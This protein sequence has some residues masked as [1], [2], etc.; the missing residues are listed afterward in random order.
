[1]RRHFSVL[2]LILG[3]LLAAVPAFAETDKLPPLVL[4]RSLS[5]E[6]AAPGDWVAISYSVR[7]TTEYPIITLTITDP[8][9]GEVGA[10]NRLEAGDSWSVTHRMSVMEDCESVPTAHYT[11]GGHE[12]RASL[13]A[14]A[15]RIEEIALLAE[16]RFET[17]Q[18]SAVTLTVT[19]QGNAPLFG[20]K[21][22][23]IALGDMGEAV[24]QLD[25]DESVTFRRASRPGG[26]YQ[27]AVTATS[28]A[29][30]PVELRSNE[31]RSETQAAP[32]ASPRPV[33]LRAGRD[34]SGQPFLTLFN[35]GTDMLRDVTIRELNRGDERTLR[36]VPAGSSAHV[37]WTPTKDASGPFSFEAAL[38]DGT[39]LATAS[40]E[41][42]EAPEATPGPDAAEGIPAL[43]GP[44]FRMNESPE[45]YRQMIRLTAIAMAVILLAWWL[46]YRRR[47]RLA[48]K[49]RLKKRQEN[50]KKQQ[51]RKKGE[52]TS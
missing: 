29:G 44:S 20:V 19:N 48:R 33:T 34:D 15:I 50:R 6:Y 10:V 21:A 30:K 52:K 45:T 1:M 36:F 11:L 17:R 23:D 2:F 41:G 27:C 49:K 47:K 28:A 4:T 40:L 8:L 26:R 35:P 7:N 22:S 24:D 31:L 46:S 38:A 13:P 9:I 3:M 5:R 18:E 12:H 16:L 42:G 43:N 39:L 14:A 51:A 37:L 25:P 32:E